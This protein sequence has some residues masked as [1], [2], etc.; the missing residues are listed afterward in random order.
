MSRVSK[1]VLIK[2]IALSTNLFNGSLHV[3]IKY[4]LKDSPNVRLIMVGEQDALGK[5]Q[6]PYLWHGL[7][8]VDVFNQILLYKASLELNSWPSHSHGKVFQVQILL[9]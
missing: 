4:Y 1:K 3:P 8:K 6:T 5:G 9:L 2:A 7:E